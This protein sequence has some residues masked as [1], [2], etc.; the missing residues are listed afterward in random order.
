ML[1]TATVALAA[2]PHIVGSTTTTVDGDTV[3]ITGKI[4]G[5]GDVGAGVVTGTAT[6]SFDVNCSNPQGRAAPGQ[7]GVTLDAGGTGSLAE[8]ADSNGNYTF[9]VVFDVPLE[10]SKAFGCPNNKWDAQPANL[11][12]TLTGLFVDGEEIDL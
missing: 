10:P 7:Q 6:L 3:T 4:A 2:N 9:T 8:T 1:I 11:T 12:A 5:L